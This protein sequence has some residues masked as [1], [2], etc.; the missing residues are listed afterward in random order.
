MKNALLVLAAAM[1]TL[2]L[3]ACGSLQPSADSSRPVVR[4]ETSLG[5]ITLELYREEAPITVENFLHY[6]ESGFYS[7]TLFHRVMKGFMIQSGGLTLDM[8]EKKTRDPIPNEAE[9]APEN[10]RGTIAM[11]RTP[12][13]HSATSQFFINTVDN[14][15]LD[16]R[17]KS[18]QGWGYCVF[19]KVIRG[20]DVVHDIESMS[21]TT[22]MGHPNVPVTP[23]ILEQAAIVRR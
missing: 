8:T 14:A 1:V 20:M 9:H 23:I 5:E 11:A 3:S 16:H 19:G 15:F 21:V 2:S 10:R 18:Q 13:P 17:D 6:V 12:A 4:L 7:G 22:K